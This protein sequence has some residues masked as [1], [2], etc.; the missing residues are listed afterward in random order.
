[1]TSV[2]TTQRDDQ[3]YIPKFYLK[4]F[5]GA[6]QKLYVYE[7]GKNY[8]ESKP[9]DEANHPDYYTHSESGTRDTTAEDS[10]QVVESRVAPIIR[11]LAS[12]QFQLTPKATG[13]LYFFIAVMFARTPAWRDNLDRMA[14]EIAKQ[15]HLKIARN[16]E[17]FLETCSSY[18]AATGKSLGDWESLRQAALSGKYE[19][20]QVSVGFN[21]GAMFGSALTV[22]EELVYF[23]CQRWYA[24]QGSFFFT[25]DFPVTTLQ[26]DGN[27]Q[28]AVGVGFALAAEVLFPVNKRLCLRLIR[29][30]PMTV[31]EISRERVEAINRLIMATTSRHLYGP[32][33]TRRN[34]RLF[35]QYGCKIRAGETAFLTSEQ[36]REY[37][38]QEGREFRML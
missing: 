18:E 4:G 24:P 31:D 29:G 8:R 16:K 11:K 28:A 6:K 15:Q 33:G 13:E 34:S 22:L 27:G 2:L 26:P 20:R 19:I 12:P 9:K 32:E 5:A 35:D 23:G 30:K 3:H 17:K 37:Q 7:K 1:V 38:R 10:L 36:L 21:L 25:S 14:G